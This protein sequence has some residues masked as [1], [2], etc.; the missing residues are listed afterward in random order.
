MTIGAVL[1]IGVGLFVLRDEP[2]D[3]GLLVGLGDSYISGEG[4][5]PYVAGTDTSTS[6]CHRSVQA[7]PRLVADQLQLD[8]RNLACSGAGVAALRTPF[9][10][11]PAQLNDTAV[12][13]AD[14]VAVM[15]GGN[16]VRALNY[17][18]DPSQAAG[19]SSV[20]TNFEPRLADALAD[21][22]RTATHPGARVIA[23]SYPS[24]LPGLPLPA[25]C[26]FDVDAGRLLDEGAAALAA[27]IE[28]AATSASVEFINLE[29]AF[30]GH[31]LC[32][33]EPWVNPFTLTNLTASLHPTAAGQ[34]RL[35]DLVAA[36]LR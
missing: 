33:T 18:F 11:Q 14:V 21:I 30:A 29:A 7:F 4:L 13:D 26:P 20:L 25:G 35:A 12:G 22:R 17:I 2:E 19:F 8:V 6:R 16:D 31:E 5:A 27:T 9:G 1:A 10:G 32:T 24:L 34:Q 36:E 23:L 3:R 28:R 15:I